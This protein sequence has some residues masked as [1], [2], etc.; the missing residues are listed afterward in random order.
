MKNSVNNLILQK[1][2]INLID[3]Y[4]MIDSFLFTEGPGYEIVLKLKKDITF[5][6]PIEK[7]ESL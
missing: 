3:G 7:K 1:K 5:N 4:E 2:L 6:I